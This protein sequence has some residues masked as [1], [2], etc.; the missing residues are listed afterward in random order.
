ML[1]QIYYYYLAILEPSDLK[2]TEL[3]RLYSHKRHPSFFGFIAILWITP[4]MG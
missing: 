3:K 2:S 4:V 1:M